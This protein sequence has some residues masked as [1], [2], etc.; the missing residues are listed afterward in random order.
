[1]ST[2]HFCDD[3]QLGDHEKTVNRVYRGLQK[4]L[5]ERLQAVIYING[6]SF[7]IKPLDERKMG[8]GSGKLEIEFTDSDSEETV[9]EKLK[10]YFEKEYAEVIGY[11]GRD[12]GEIARIDIKKY[13]SW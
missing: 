4:V 6:A 7:Y 12:I 3:M 8:F 11:G 13:C 9:K 1:M 2:A 5:K 10:A